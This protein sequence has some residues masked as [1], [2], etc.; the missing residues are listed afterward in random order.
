MNVLAVAARYRTDM[1]FQNFKTRES[2]LDNLQ[3]KS[4]PNAERVPDLVRRIGD[5][6]IV[7]A[8][9]SANDVITHSKLQNACDYLLSSAQTH[10]VRCEQAQKN[11]CD[12]CEADSPASCAWTH[13]RSSL[14]FAQSAQD[15]RAHGLGH[16][17]VDNGAL[18]C[19]ANPHPRFQIARA[20][21]TTFQVTHH[22]TRRLNQKFVAKIRI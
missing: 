7:V 13:K 17:S 19:V 1:S 8:F 2:L 11:E 18:Q 12:T 21:F 3:E 5:V 22:F 6:R 10:P 14:R 9:N 20:G 4:I 15:I 16:R